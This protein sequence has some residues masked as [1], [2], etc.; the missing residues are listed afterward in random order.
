MATSQ[1]SR[2]AGTEPQAPLVTG[3]PPFDQRYNHQMLTKG[4]MIQ[5]GGGNIRTPLVHFLFRGHVPVND[6]EAAG[7][8]REEDDND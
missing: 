3:S 5:P 1:H 7:D 8:K 6:V 2:K 4:T